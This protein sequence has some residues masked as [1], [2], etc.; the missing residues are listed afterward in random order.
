MDFLFCFLLSSPKTKIINARKLN[1]WLHD[2]TRIFATGRQQLRVYG[3]LSFTRNVLNCS[4]LCWC[5]RFL[6]LNTTNRQTNAHI[7]N[8]DAFMVFES[9]P[10]RVGKWCRQSRTQWPQTKCGIFSLFSVFSILCVLGFF[11]SASFGFERRKM[12]DIAHAHVHY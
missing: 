12:L 8:G 4:L 9:V 1:S 2:G 11:S 7:W 3:G 5:Q 6:A 10:H